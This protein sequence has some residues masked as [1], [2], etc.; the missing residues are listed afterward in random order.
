MHDSHPTD[1]ATDLHGQRVFVSTTVEHLR[2]EGRPT[3][4]PAF[5]GGDTMR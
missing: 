1:N 4:S 2:E 5:D 3:D